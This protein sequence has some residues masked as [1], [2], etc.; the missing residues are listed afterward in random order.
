MKFLLDNTLYKVIEEGPNDYLLEDCETGKIWV[1][2]NKQDKDLIE[3]NND[4]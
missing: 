3:V 1:Q 4:K 2:V